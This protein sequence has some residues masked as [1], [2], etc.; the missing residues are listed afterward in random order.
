MTWE[1]QEVKVVATTQLQARELVW[2][3]HQFDIQP[4]SDAENTLKLVGNEEMKIPSIL[5]WG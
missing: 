4:Y 1:S 5:S 2:D 3:I